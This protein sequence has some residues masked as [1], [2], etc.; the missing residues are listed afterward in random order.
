M[1]ST[2]AIQY[3][4]REHLGQ[5]R[6]NRAARPYITHPIAVMEIVRK[7]ARFSDHMNLC[8]EQAAVLHDTIEDT[9]TTYED[10]VINFNLIVAN[11]VQ[12]LTN[13]PGIHGKEKNEEQRAKAK[14]YSDA[15]KLVKFADRLDNCSSL[16][17]DPPVGWSTTRIDGYIQHSMDCIIL[18]DIA[19][20]IDIFND[21]VYS[22]WFGV[23]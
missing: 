4:T 12:E 2:S 11:I 18:M 1:S 21:E 8:C 9:P 17:T 13:T 10:L 19:E 5:F 6:K 15:A 23:N 14:T 7:Y 20:Y 16:L 22:K 3:A